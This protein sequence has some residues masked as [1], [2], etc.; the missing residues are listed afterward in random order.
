MDARPPAEVPLLDWRA[1]RHW[2]NNPR[3]CKW[4]GQPTHLRDSKRR[5]SHKVCAE[6]AIATQAADMAD[7]YQ[8]GHLA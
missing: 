5:A 4:C 1:G 6:T 8:K 2:S 3:P 7:A